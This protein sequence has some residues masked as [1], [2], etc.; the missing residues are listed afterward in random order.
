M[1]EKGLEIPQRK[2]CQQL[3]QQCACFQ[4][5]AEHDSDATGLHIIACQIAVGEAG[6]RDVQTAIELYKKSAKLNTPVVGGH[7]ISMER[8]A[9]H[10]ERGIGVKQD[11]VLACDWYN[12]VLNHPGI[13]G[14]ESMHLA[15]VTLSRF[16]K[17]GL[18]VEKCEHTAT[19]YLAISKSNPESA[20]ELKDLEQW[21]DN[22]S[23]RDKAKSI[24]F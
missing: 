2:K 9:G 4:R 20:A 6:I 14:E 18:G 16:Y 21:W 3:K 17:Q 1:P 5:N 23:E 22:A 10:Y 19:K 13:V 11:Y 15:L 7:P 24:A 12:R 8:L